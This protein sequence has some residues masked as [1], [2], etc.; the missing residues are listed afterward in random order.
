MQK[1]KVILHV[2]ESSR[3]RLAYNNVNNILK[4][5]EEVIIEVLLNSEAAALATS[6]EKIIDLLSKNVKVSVCNNSL[7]SLN[8][9]VNDILEGVVVVPVGVLE[10]VY[11]QNEAYAYIKP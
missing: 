2:S 5:N 6:E 4:A 11:K 7:N 10:L 8:I 9:N 3:F 1:L